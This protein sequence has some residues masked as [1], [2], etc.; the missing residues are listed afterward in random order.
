MKCI[1]CSKE[2]NN[3]KEICDKC[4]EKQDKEKA[5]QAKLRAKNPKFEKVDSENSPEYGRMV[6]T[7]GMRSGIISLVSAVTSLLFS[8]FI[9]PGLIFGILAIVE[10][11]LT[12]VDVVRNNRRG[13][14]RMLPLAF[15]IIGTCGG[16]IALIITFLSVLSVII[17]FITGTP[18]LI[19]AFLIALIF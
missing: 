16:A 7:T 14:K 15:G 17:F 19:L 11:A 3:E 13:H 18:V 5:K 9:I 2:T 12:I 8:I 6:Y 10:G 4:Q 1:M